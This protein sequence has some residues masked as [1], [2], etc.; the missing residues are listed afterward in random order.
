MPLVQNLLTLPPTPPNTHPPHSNTPLP[1]PG[2]LINISLDPP[3]HTTITTTLSH[4]HKQNG[5][6]KYVRFIFFKN[7]LNQIHSVHALE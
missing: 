2:D 5:Y 6:L 3:I 4:Q 7:S 1:T